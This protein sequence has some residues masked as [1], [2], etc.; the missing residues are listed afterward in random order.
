MRLVQT[1]SNKGNLARSSAQLHVKAKGKMYALFVNNS[2][3]DLFQL[4]TCCQTVTL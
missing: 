3:K 4:L 2:V 1:L